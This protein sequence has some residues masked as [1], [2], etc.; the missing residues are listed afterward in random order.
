M[1]VTV[2]K[3]LILLGGL[4]PRLLKNQHLLNSGNSVGRIHPHASSCQHRVY[5]VVIAYLRTQGCQSRHQER[6]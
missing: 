1:G 4:T 3:S 5:L 2:V 6:I